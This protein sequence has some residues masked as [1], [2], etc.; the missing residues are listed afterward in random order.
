[1]LG[2]DSAL[3]TILA[4]GGAFGVVLVLIILGLLVPRW[5]VTD[6]KEE[7]SELKATVQSERA[8]ADAATTAAQGSRD[9]IAALQSGLQIGMR[10]GAHGEQAGT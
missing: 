3:V 10:E 1:V 4:N 2:V 8:R 5:V 9:V 6:L 7:N